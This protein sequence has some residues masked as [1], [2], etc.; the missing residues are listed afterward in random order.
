MPVLSIIWE[1]GEGNNLLLCQESIIVTNAF[2][3]SCN[4]VQVNYSALV[5]SIALAYL[6]SAAWPIFPLSGKLITI[7]FQPTKVNGREESFKNIY[8]KTVKNIFIK[9]ILFYFSVW[10]ADGGE[11]VRVQR[12]VRG[13]R[14]GALLVVGRVWQEVRRRLVHLHHVLPGRPLQLRPQQSTPTVSSLALL[15]FKFY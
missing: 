12:R 10:K 8:C 5:H 11:E 13:V 7:Q 4:Y 15:S 6:I 1:L 9:I 3:S 2:F 14:G